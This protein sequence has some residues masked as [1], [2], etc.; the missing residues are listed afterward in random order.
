MIDTPAR[1][2][3]LKKIHLFYGLEEVELATVADQLIEAV[4]AA[5]STI[6]E[7]DKKAD[8]FY[9]IYSGN[10][11]IVRKQ[12]GKEIPVTTL[13]T[14]DYFGEMALID[15]RRRSGTARA[16]TD[17]TLLLLSRD[18]FLKLLKQS[19]QFKLNLDVTIRSRR[20][21][22]SLQFNWLAKDEVIYF[23][24]RKHFIVLLKSLILP[25]LVMIVPAFLLFWWADVARLWI[26]F[27]AGAASLVFVVLWIIWQ[28]LDWRNDYYIVTNRRVVWL[29]RIIAFY[30]SRQ[31]SPLT[32]ILAVAVET[33]LLGRWLDFG[34]VIVRTYVGKI[35]FRSVSHPRQAQRM[36]EEYW[37]RTKE[38]AVGVEK[39]AM[40]NTLRKK[41]GLPVPP[42]PE[43]APPK[44]AD[45]PRE[46]GVSRLFRL[47]GT[48]R[49]RL[50][51][52][53]GD[54]VIYRKHWFV[55][56]RQAWIPLLGMFTVIGVFFYRL[57]SLYRNPQDEF[58]SM[59]NGLAIDPFSSAMGIV[60]FL[61]M[62][63]LIYEIV[64]WSNDIYQVTNE[65]IIDMD[66]KPLGTQTR[67]ASQLE[68]I[69]GTEYKRV[70]LLGEIFNFGTVYITVGSTKLTFDD[71]ID[72]AT[73]QS[74]IDRR[75]LAQQD[76]KREKQAATERERMAEWLIA[77]HQNAEVFKREQDQRQNPE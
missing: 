10:V 18:N 74:D 6:F 45:F 53:V 72:P 21:A 43:K 17:T 35:V 48:D 75:R 26:V 39:E 2:A 36:V 62:V 12:Q 73:V 24:A 41:L 33:D 23:L 50:R 28:V 51:Y 76:R 3:F 5:G 70:G 77:Y 68:N 65:Q 58:V 19:N 31:E 59:E 57:Y 20:L 11:K 49:L 60:F 38:Q 69:L 54:S 56:I 9:L 29:E 71:V 47:F 14:N 61:L 27:I 25:V 32:T 8:N 1:L 63:W 44:T 34:D 64:D 67:N 66:K 37:E 4:F 22:H 40:K 42:P 46:K 16:S 55:L 7:Q 52:E 15:R 13:V 30:D